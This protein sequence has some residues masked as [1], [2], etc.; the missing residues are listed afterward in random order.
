MQ[1]HTEQEARQ[2]VR[3][4]VQR[5]KTVIGLQEAPRY[6]LGIKNP[7][8]DYLG[9]IVKEEILPL[10]DEG[11]YI[12]NDPPIIV[13]DP[14]SSDSDRLNFTF[15]HEVSHH[16]IYQ[17]NELYSFLHEYASVNDKH[18][19]T[20]LERY[21]NVGA[22]DFLIPADEVREVIEERGFSIKMIQYLEPIYPA[23]KP[24]IAI[25]LAQCAT[26]Q[27]FVVVCEW[28][29]MPQQQI[30]QASFTSSVSNEPRLYVLY[31]SSSPSTK[32]PIGRFVPV[33]S[34]HVIALAYQSQNVV[35]DTAPILF[36]NGN[37]RWKC[38]CEA[39]YY[40]GKVY[41][42]FNASPPTSPKQLRL[43]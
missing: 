6:L 10:G 43:F 21:C 2:R 28:G 32:Y 3:E 39:F 16:L 11:Q 42:T 19:D 23:S 17:D 24:A 4:L 22:A 18:F 12:P 20:A 30:P 37:R 34:D 35:K 13:I 9:I 7:I 26:H 38:E 1:I 8:A 29:Q 27:C 33:P 36:R 15:F 40:K 14:W 5:T 25:Q 31:A 41:A